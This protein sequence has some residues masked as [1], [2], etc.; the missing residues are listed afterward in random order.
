MQYPPGPR[1]FFPGQFMFELLRDPI[2]MLRS[3]PRRFGGIS[4]FTVG[5][6]HVYFVNEP[7]LIKDVLVTHGRNF[8]KSR[9]LQRAKRMLGEGLLTSEDPSHMKQRRLM[10]PA[11]H[12]QRIEAYA[13]VM[14]DY[15]MR[16]REAWRDGETLDV[17]E[18]RGDLALDIV[19]KTLLDAEVSADSAAIRESLYDSMR[20]FR[21]VMVPFSELLDNLPLP[22]VRRFKRARA[23]LDAIVY[24]MIEEHRDGR[25]RGDLLSMLLAA[26][27][28]DK[29]R[30]TD[31]QL[32]DEVM[33]IFLAGHETTANALTWTWYLLS[34][35]PEVKARFHAEIDTVL[36]GRPP[37]LEDVSRLGYVRRV[38][39][40]SMRMF[41][42][43]GSWAAAPSAPA[44]S[45]DIAWRPARSFSSASWSCTTTSAFFRIRRNSS[46]IAFS[47]SMRKGARNSHTSRSAAEI[48]C[49]SASSSPGWKASCC[50]PR[51]ARNGACGC[52]RATRWQCSR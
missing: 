12:R 11:F 2:P 41:P 40:E 1:Q 33:T 49:A 4:H 50:W 32:R 51:W 44:T 16:M 15:A 37:R 7:D 36:A 19:G 22:A 14:V 25:D 34:Q 31:V 38:L 30:M 23:R 10:Q 24:R 29:S 20:S 17:C 52:R 3:L 8:T 45:R 35:N 39:C 6:V 42:R 5:P 43:P 27:D 28:E 18:A 46:R 48:A 26:Q 13:S 47:P 21:M 9:G